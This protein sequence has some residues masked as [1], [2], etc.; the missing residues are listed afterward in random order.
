[1]R[2][3]NVYCHLC[4]RCEQSF[5]SFHSIVSCQICCIFRATIS[6]CIHSSYNNICRF[7]MSLIDEWCR[8]RN[9]TLPIICESFPAKHHTTSDRPRSFST[10]STYVYKFCK[11]E[12]WSWI[13]QWMS[14]PM[15]KNVI[16]FGFESCIIN[17]IMRK[18]FIFVEAFDCKIQII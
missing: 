14:Q 11:F 12:K 10:A 1:M 15:Q 3:N 4:T 13:L 18:N 16:L 17:L 6:M 7:C 8:L 5:N 9:A 2:H